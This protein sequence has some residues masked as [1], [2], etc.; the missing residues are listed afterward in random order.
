MTEERIQPLWTNL[1]KQ[2]PVLRSIHDDSALIADELNRLP[3][4]YD[5]NHQRI[6]A[7]RKEIINPDGSQ[8]SIEI[9]EKLKPL[10]SIAL[11][12][13][14]GVVFNT[15]TEN[16]Q[17][18]IYRNDDWDKNIRDTLHQELL[19]S[20]EAFAHMVETRQHPE[21]LIKS[22]SALGF[23]SKKAV[24]SILNEVP[25]DYLLHRGLIV[26]KK[27]EELDFFT[28]GYKLL[29][30]EHIVNGQSSRFTTKPVDKTSGAIPLMVKKEHWVPNDF[31]LNQDCIKTLSPRD[32]LYIVEGQHDMLA[33]MG[34]VG[35][36]NVIATVGCLSR[37]QTNRIARYAEKYQVV[38]LFDN[39]KSG[40]KYAKE[41][42]R[43]Y[44]LQVN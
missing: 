19:N 26:V 18:G 41:V 39:D 10:S 9:L 37:E 32:R 38:L 15:E 1:V 34:K 28:R 22:M 33:V 29:T 40:E 21:E 43:E 42:I 24:Y 14:L 44:A 35:I 7:I 3:G 8:R 27:D 31:L 25:N 13:M 4:M 23:S 6:S 36:N 17:R 20:D 12:E 30:F 2:V 16:F 11:S 5:N